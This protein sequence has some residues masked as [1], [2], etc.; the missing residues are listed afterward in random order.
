MK[1]YGTFKFSTVDAPQPIAG[2]CE[3][4]SYRLVDQVYEVQGE[5]DIEGIVLHGRKGEISF[6]S[7]P[8]GGVTALGVRA[9]AELTI[10]GVSGGK[11]IVT[12]SS[13]KWSRGQ[14][15]VFDAQATH[16]PD[17]S[18]S[19]VGTI[20]PASFEIAN[21]SGA[22]QL[23]TNKIWWSVEGLTA[24]V[25]GIVQSCALT[26]TVQV[27]E[28]ADAEGLIVATAVHGY[29]ATANM[30]ILTSGDAPAPGTTFDVFGDFRV[31]SSESKWQKGQMRLVSVE[32]ILIPGVTD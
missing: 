27:H 8:S 9:G 22:I 18:A 24:A 7:T 13:A 23:P 15:M 12:S 25:A 10:T 30:E 5:S 28:E 17:L 26:E 2:I 6:S 21:A 29:K 11:V 31:T 20:T 3:S 16:F 4:F 32:G 1:T 19:G 14:A